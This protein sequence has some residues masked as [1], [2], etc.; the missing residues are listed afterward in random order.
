MKLNNYKLVV[1]ATG[2]G[3]RIIPDVLEAGGA[4]E[5]LLEAIVP[6]S[7]QSLIDLLGRE[8]R[9]KS[10]SSSTA[11]EMAI[12][13]FNRGVKQG[14]QNTIGAAI[15][16]SLARVGGEREGRRH[17]VFMAVYSNH[18]VF[19]YQY[20][21]E[22][23]ESQ[24]D[25]QERK[26]ARIFHSFIEWFGGY[27]NSDDKEKAS[28]GFR[29]E[30][31]LLTQPSK[32]IL[33]FFK[34]ENNFKVFEKKPAAGPRKVC[35]FPGSFNPLHTGH[36]YI[37]SKCLGLFGEGNVYY[38]LS[39]KNFDKP[40]IDAIEVGGRV[41][42]FSYD[43]L[44][45]SKL[46]TFEEKERA[47]KEEFGEV[48]FAIGQDTFERMTGEISSELLVF[49]RNGEK[50]LDNQSSPYKLHSATFDLKNGP[51]ISSSQIRKQRDY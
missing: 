32:I 40:D 11:R 37:Y 13:G 10:V 46:P 31:G 28:E 29:Y 22:K 49:P 45:L 20:I 34:L 27:L 42:R 30:E 38:E 25:F 41:N 33:D 39:V 14:Y 24:R 48:V 35:I 23:T 43:N 4:S 21:F 26:A 51:A 9:E 3:T 16:C 18:E 15:T 36:K 47:Y 1:A 2:G 8:P 12:A 6:Y 44:I 50:I 17:E 5:F 7:P 19:V